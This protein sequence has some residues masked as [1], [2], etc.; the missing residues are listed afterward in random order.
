MNQ[1]ASAEIGMNKT[2]TATAPH[3]AK[4]M[5]ESSDELGSAPEGERSANDLRLEYIESAEKIGSIP[6]P[7]SIKGMTKSALTALKGEKATVLIDKL[8]ERLAFE[9][10]G[11]RLYEALLLKCKAVNGSGGSDSSE[12]LEHICAEE[13]EHFQM[14]W[15]CLEQLGADPTV[16]TPSADL[17][18][19]ASQGIPKVL[20]D[21]RTTF[22]QCLEA[23][24]MAEVVDYDAWERLIELADGFNQSEMTDK[25][26]QALDD[27]RDHLSIIRGLLA[28]EVKG[29]AGVSVH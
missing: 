10:S 28:H 23:I 21:P 26:R 4:E 27:E 18:A 13:A 17:A 11:V 19:V 20:L 5:I 29:E 12:Q 15:Q 25:F 14:L 2:G 8:A 1:K 16:E 6:P 7:T 9:R 22:A 3:L 24:M